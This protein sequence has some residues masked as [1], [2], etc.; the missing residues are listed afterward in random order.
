MWLYDSGRGGAAGRDAGASTAD[1]GAANRPEQPI[2]TRDETFDVF[3]AHVDPGKVGIF[4]SLGVDIVMGRREGVFFYDAF[5]GR[6]YFDCHCNGG[7]FNL[8]HRN[9]RILG[10]LSDALRDLDVGNHH[11]VSPWRAELARRLAASTRDV[12][13]GAVFAPGG[14][15]AVD[16]AI[17]FSRGFTGRRKV[18]SIEGGYHG[19]TGFAMAAG[20]PRY[21]DPFGPNLPG[22]VQVPPG[23]LD[24]MGA[25]IGEDTA[26]VIL[27]PIPATLGMPLP[28]PGYLRSVQ[29]L[30]ASSGAV[31]ILDEIQTGLGRTGNI[32]YFLEE[33][34]KPDVVVVGKG[35][36]GGVYPMAAAILGPALFEWFGRHPFVHVSTFGGAEPGCAVALR[37][38]DIVEDPG[39]LGHVR[40]VGEYL[41][42][43]VQDLPFELRRQGMM[44][45]FKFPNLG[46]GVIAAAKLIREGVFAVY[47]NNDTSCVQFLPPLT[48]SRAEAEELAG[49]V[50][51]ALG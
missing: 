44:M 7:V 47:A 22:F 43:E 38:M 3:G 30:C 46:D 28:E 19:H 17:K 5:D 39:F 8:G 31:F 32:W 33:D 14:G 10:A 13:T 21:R 9:P 48:I 24:A 20:D 42:G 50:R 2:S 51:S 49:R 34:L 45:S 29:E 18:V 16:V 26:C 23:D 41:E 25:A 4:R 40:A 36:S 12:L 1:D 27:E 6:R 37:V 11:L 15:E 35:L